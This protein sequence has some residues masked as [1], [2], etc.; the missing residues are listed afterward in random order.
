MRTK[1]TGLG[2]WEEM[3]RM[4]FRSALGPK[5]TEGRRML[6]L[7]LAQSAIDNSPFFVMAFE[8]AAPTGDGDYSAASFF[9]DHAHESVGDRRT[10]AGAKALAERRIAT[11][12]T[13]Q[14][15]AKRCGCSTIAAPPDSQ[16]RMRGKAA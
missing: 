16:R 13:T 8:T 12:Q 3:P 1:G 9:A 7:C 2:R 15:S 6:V 14:R 11:W 10:L 4:F 5:R